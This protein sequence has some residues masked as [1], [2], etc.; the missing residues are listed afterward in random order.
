MPKEVL[1]LFL[2]VPE[3]ISK[4]EEIHLPRQQ[5]ASSHQG[6]YL[7]PRPSTVG[8]LLLVIRGLCKKV[9]GYV[10]GGFSDVGFSV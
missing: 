9:I 5:C 4:V 1:V 2:K 7:I 6:F 3:Y 8:F 10:D